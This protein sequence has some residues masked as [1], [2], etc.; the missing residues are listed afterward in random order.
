[1]IEINRLLDENNVKSAFMLFQRFQEKAG[2]C[3]TSS[4]LILL[5][6]RFEAD[7]RS[8]ITR[9]ARELTI[10]NIKK[11]FEYIPKYSQIFKTN[12]KNNTPVEKIDYTSNCALLQESQEIFSLMKSEEEFKELFRKQFGDYLQNAI[13]KNI[14]PRNLFDKMIDLFCF[15]SLYETFRAEVFTNDIPQI[16]LM[17]IEPHFIEKLKVL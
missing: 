4:K 15:C 1:M 13:L 7:F 8:N 2:S 14:D 11:N 9:K 5:I 3:R 10:K 17:S 16:S 12:F 6:D